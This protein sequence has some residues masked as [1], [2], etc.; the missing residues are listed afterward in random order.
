L[1]ALNAIAA[2][3]QFFGYYRMPYYFVLFAG[4]ALACVYVPQFRGRWRRWGTVLLHG[5]AAVT[6]AAVVLIPWGLRISGGPLA[7]KVS[8]G[9]A[10]GRSMEMVRSQLGQWGLLPRY[11]SQY[12]LFIAAVGFVWAAV[13]GDVFA[14]ATGVWAISMVAIVAAKLVGVPGTAFLDSFASMIFMYAPIALLAAWV[15]ARLAAWFGGL[16]YH[17]SVLAAVA[18]LLVTLFGTYRALSVSDPAHDLVEQAD[19]AAM[20]WIRDNTLSSAR[21]L[22]NGFL[23][24]DGRSAVG[25]DAGWWI[26]LLARRAN[27]MPPQYALLTETELEPGYGRRVVDIVAQ[28]REAS[29]TTEQGL[30]TLCNEQIT[31][32]YVGQGQGRVASP[33]SEPLYTPEELASSPLFSEV[34]H[35][36]RVW[37]FELADGACDR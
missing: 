26:P 8:L 22:V 30:Q 16:S 13:R 28:L 32:V 12:L 29:V 9:V 7:T 21:F 5:V 11:V 27:T 31:H 3:G 20:E 25:S 1:V 35:R 18:L 6:L 17:G 24:Y 10:R 4:S 14:I 36:D 33:P 19:M 37:I 34:Y 15:G 2:V 23:I